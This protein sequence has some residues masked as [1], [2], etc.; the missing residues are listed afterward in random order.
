MQDD[1]KAYFVSSVVQLDGQRAYEVREV[2]KASAERLKELSDKADEIDM[3]YEK[4]TKQID[5][6]EQTG[7][8]A[9]SVKREPAKVKNELLALADGAQ[10]PELK[11]AIRKCADS[12][13]TSP[14]D[15]G[16]RVE[17][18]DAIYSLSREVHEM[19]RS[20]KMTVV[21]EYRGLLDKSPPSYYLDKT[22]AKLDMKTARQDERQEYL[23]GS[24]TLLKSGQVLKE[25]EMKGLVQSGK[26]VPEQVQQKQAR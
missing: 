20:E 22:V 14:A 10:K 4:P 17:N 25:E 24:A 13:K 23:H 19:K 7:G 11:A 8:L 9:E 16:Q 15:F 6:D 5:G 2:S 3:R 21:Q 12:L 1:D 18:S 26:L